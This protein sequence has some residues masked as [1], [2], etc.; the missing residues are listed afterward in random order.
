MQSA[1]TKKQSPENETPIDAAKLDQF[2]N[3]LFTDLG[4]ATTATMVLVGDKLGL[5]K[6]MADG[7]PVTPSELAKRAET[8][9]TPCLAKRTAN[10]LHLP[11]FPSPRSDGACHPDPSLARGFGGRRS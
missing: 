9:L 7:Q 11:P 6:A 2:M 3:Q 5:Y 4:G 1:Q 8:P 10:S